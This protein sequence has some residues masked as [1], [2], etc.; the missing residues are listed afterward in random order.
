VRKG[1]RS[2]EVEMLAGPEGQQID[3][4][5]YFK[6]KMFTALKIPKSY[7]SMDETAGH[8][9]LAQMDIRY[10]KSVMRVQREFK[11]GM[12]QV[13]RVDLA[14]KNIDPDRVDYSAKMVIPSGAMELAQ[15][16]VQN[17][18]LDLGGRYRDAGFSEY[19]IWSH[20]LDMSDEDIVRIRAERKK[21]QGGGEGEVDQGELEAQVDR[22]RDTIDKDAVRHLSQIH[23]EIS[24]SRTEFSKRIKEVRMLMSEMRYALGKGFDTIRKKK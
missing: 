12:A 4:V 18:K 8:A 2:S 14:T 6:D 3:D 10:C 19:Y 9:N 13:A 5:N 24:E 16:E 21:E 20:I 17:A 7:L 23:D 11:N 22:E 15:V 1:K